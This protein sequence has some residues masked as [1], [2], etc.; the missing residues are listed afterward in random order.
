MILIG[1]MLAGLMA[2][3]LLGWWKGWLFRSKWLMWCFVFSV[4]A[5]Q[6]GNQVGWAVAELGRQPW[7][8]YGMLRTK[9]AVSPTLT[10]GQAIASL[11]MF[12]VI[13]ALLLALF[14]YQI[15]HKIHKGP[16]GVDEFD[17]TGQGRLHIPF[18]KE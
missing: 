8:V 16:D 7:I 18:I 9:D 12:G 4:L 2:L 14:I 1:C 13:Y 10:S 5:P 15:S 6:I 3:G 17:D 11:A